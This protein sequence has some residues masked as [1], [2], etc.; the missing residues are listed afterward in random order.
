MC[1]KRDKGFLLLGF[2]SK[3]IHTWTQLYKYLP[4]HRARLMVRARSK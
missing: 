1:G 3:E 4:R 2:T